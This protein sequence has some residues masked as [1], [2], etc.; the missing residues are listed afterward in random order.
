[1]RVLWPFVTVGKLPASLQMIKPPRPISRLMI[2]RRV[3]SEFQ[4][5][6]PRLL[7]LNPKIASHKIKSVSLSK[8]RLIEAG[9]TF[10]QGYNSALTLTSLD[11]VETALNSIRVELRGFAYEGAALGA[12]VKDALP[13]SSGSMLSELV[14]RTKRD[15]IY[16]VHVGAGWAL[17][18]LRWRR[19]A[20]L[21]QLDPVLSWLAWDGCG[22]HDLFFGRQNP[23]RYPIFRRLRGYEMRAYDQ[24]LGRALWF[25]AE[26]DP[27]QVIKLAGQFTLSRRGDVF[28]GIGL[29]AAYAGGC[30]AEDL[31]TLRNC[32][33]PYAKQLAQGAAFAAEAR[34]RARSMVDH[35]NLAC[36][37]LCE[38]SGDAAAQVVRETHQLLPTGSNTDA[39]GTIYEQWRTLVQARFG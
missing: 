26:A 39:T 13:F 14:R 2:A 27:Q 28:S 20:I 24:G 34:S 6:A 7:T 5:L 10:I 3:A 38:C 21:A 8:H 36:L 31:K 1:M 25:A 16:L 15:H 22:F 37:I 29:A 12:A 18:R 17:G 9:T 32:A 19:A 35:T 11:D 4:C 33:G 23:N 30:V